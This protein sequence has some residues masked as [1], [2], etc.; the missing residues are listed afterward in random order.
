VAKEPSA[1]VSWF[2]ICANL[3]NPCL[4]ICQRCP[5]SKQAGAIQGG[6]GVSSI[7]FVSKEICFV[8]KQMGFAWE[9]IGFVVKRSCFAAKS[10][11]SVLASTRFA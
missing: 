9:Q 2:E 4:K 3:C 11:R 1:R 6:K 5:N 8:P 10:I 7:C